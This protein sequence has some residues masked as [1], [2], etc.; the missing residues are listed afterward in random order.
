MV[1]CLEKP[2]LE[3]ITGASFE[4]RIGKTSPFETSMTTSEHNNQALLQPLRDENKWL[5]TACATALT[6]E[7]ATLFIPEPITKAGSLLIGTVSINLAVKRSRKIGN[8][9]KNAEA[10]DEAFKEEKIQ[11]FPDLDVPGNG[12]LDLLV[13]F[14][15]PPKKAVFSIALRSQGKATVF[16]NEQKEALYIRTTSGGLKRWKP[17]HIERLAL[18]EFWLRQNRQEELFGTSSR[19][20]N[21]AVVKLL[22]LTG[23]TKTGQHSD[24]LYTEVGDQRVLLL[25]RRSSVYVLHEEQLIPFIK[26]W[27]AQ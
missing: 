7:A 23:Q 14:P 4:E 22:V 6:F 1:V 19:D 17:D 16:Y 13:K 5:G 27:L 18:Q 20:K 21:R 24:S 15:L 9:I 11:I 2:S 25:R 3:L 8:V 10:L 12:R 26:A